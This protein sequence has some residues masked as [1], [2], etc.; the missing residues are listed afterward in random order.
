MN[1]KT[2]LVASLMTIS[3]VACSKKENAENKMDST[4]AK[5]DSA[6]NTTPANTT[7]NT[8][9]STP[10]DTTQ[11]AVDA[12]ATPKVSAQSTDT[13]VVQDKAKNDS[14]VNAGT[15]PAKK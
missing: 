10:L 11:K 2:L 7:T 6:A 14:L 1:A 3:L 15:T 4:A 8:T 5:I 12:N 9:P 13:A